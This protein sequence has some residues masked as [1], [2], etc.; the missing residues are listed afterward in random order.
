MRKGA[1]VDID[2]I[3]KESIKDPEFGAGF[4]AE[5]KKLV[6]SIKK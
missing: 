4:K 2:K 5:Y 3:F 6:E 1:L